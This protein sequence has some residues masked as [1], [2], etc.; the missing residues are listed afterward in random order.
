MNK[1][2]P[3][4]HANRQTPEE[5]DRL[6][7]FT[8]GVPQGD[9]DATVGGEIAAQ[10]EGNDGRDAPVATSREE[11]VEQLGD[12]RRQGNLSIADEAAILREYDALVVEL[13]A[14]KVRL[15]AEFRDRMARDGQEQTHAWLAEAAA[16]LGRR[17]GEQ[18]RRLMRTVPAFAENVQG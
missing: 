16:A 9:P 14:E 7:D 2:P 1:R 5:G 6:P 8:G 11:F 3:Q 17:Q 10:A 13:R 18:M 4:R 12:L 15:E